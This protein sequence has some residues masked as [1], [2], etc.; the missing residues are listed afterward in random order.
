MQSQIGR[1]PSCANCHYNAVAENGKRNPIK[2]LAAV[3]HI[4][5]TTNQ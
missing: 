2:A 1:E 4:Y 5:L 3:G